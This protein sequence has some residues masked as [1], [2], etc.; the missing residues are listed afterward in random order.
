MDRF[1]PLEVV[2]PAA[3][4]TETVDFGFDPAIWFEVSW[5]GPGDLRSEDGLQVAIIEHEPFSPGGEYKFWVGE[6]YTAG[7]QP[8][9]PGYWSFK[10]ELLRWHVPLVLRQG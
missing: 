2:F 6:S 9:A 10:A 3:M 5:Q 1:A 7:G 8:V 4:A